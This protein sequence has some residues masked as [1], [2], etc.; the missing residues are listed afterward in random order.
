MS[1]KQ[2]YRLGNRIL[3][4][5]TSRQPM[6][7]LRLFGTFITHGSEYR[8]R[9]TSFAYMSSVKHRRYI[10]T[11]AIAR[12]LPDCFADALSMNG[13]DDP[14]NAVNMKVA[15]AQ[16]QE[17][18]RALRMCIPV[19]ELPAVSSFDKDENGS[20]QAT[21]N[22]PD[23]VFVE[24]TVIAIGKD[25]LVTRMGHPSRRG[26]EK[27]VYEVLKQLGMDV[28]N[29]NDYQDSAEWMLGTVAKDGNEVATVDGGDVLFTGRHLFVGLSNRTNVEGANFILNF[30]A[31]HDVIV[32]P[33]L[34]LPG[35][36]GQTVPLHLKS[37]VTHIDTGTLLAPVGPIG[38][39]FLE[40]MRVQEL[41]YTVHRLP[42]MLSC[43]VVACNGLVIAQDT[44]C[45]ESRRILRDA[46]MEANQDLIMVDT[47]E[48]AKKDGALTCCSVLLEA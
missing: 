45:R 10:Y 40:A 3:R 21:K 13:D 44:S 32:L 5:R 2:V 33:Q 39:L 48:L 12:Q 41:G 18:V 7:P 1:W 24:D 22:H 28:F 30:F 14:N 27:Q 36:T 11:I 9:V 17:Y 20:I 34:H 16:H 46:V 15:R 37:A 23:C 42:D 38:D 6:Q 26:E 31:S 19:L 29:M 47:S 4:E 25:A 35:T 8:S 43:N